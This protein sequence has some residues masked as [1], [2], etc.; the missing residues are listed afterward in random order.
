MGYRV[1]YVGV[2]GQGV[3]HLAQLVVPVRELAAAAQL[4]LLVFLNN[5]TLLEVS[6]N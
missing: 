2:V 6:A 1:Y 3:V 5:L 4:A